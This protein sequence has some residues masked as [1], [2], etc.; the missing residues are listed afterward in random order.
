[1][2][3]LVNHEQNQE[4]LVQ[5]L[6]QLRKSNDHDITL[7]YLKLIGIFLVFGKASNEKNM[8]SL[9]VPSN[10]VNELENFLNRTCAF[11]FT[12]VKNFYFGVS[13]IRFFGRQNIVPINIA[14][15]LIDVDDD[16]AS[17]RKNI[18][19]FLLKRINQTLSNENCTFTEKECFCSILDGFFF[20]KRMNF[21]E[22]TRSATSGHK[23]LL[24]EITKLMNKFVNDDGVSC[25]IVDEGIKSGTFA[26]FD[27]VMKLFSMNV[28]HIRFLI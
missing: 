23:D 14:D 7:D 19:K 4:E 27:G 15:V 11:K 22:M 25:E 10:L 12:V 1:M 18:T 17:Q 5:Q 28:F 8:V 26:N 2:L 3:S 9:F 13:Q 24:V 16:N 20:G 21:K 6:E